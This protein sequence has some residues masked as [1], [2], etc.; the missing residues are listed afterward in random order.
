MISRN[1]DGV[2]RQ[3]Y[4]H[5]KR[6]LVPNPRQNERPLTAAIGY[7]DSG[8]LRSVRTSDGRR[9]DGDAIAFLISVLDEAVADGLRTVEVVVTYR[10]S[11]SQTTYTTTIDNL[12]QHGQRLLGISGWELAMPRDQWSINGHA[13]VA[14]L[15]AQAA[16]FDMP[17]A[18]GTGRK[19]AY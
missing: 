11:Q 5:T 14:E 7:F 6:Y 1:D 17:A 4:A 15:P 16:L 13:P 18:V 10:R 12:R 2:N 8:I 9:Y 3:A 19:A